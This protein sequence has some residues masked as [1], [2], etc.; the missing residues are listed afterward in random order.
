M[1]PSQST[2]VFNLHG[3]HYYEDKSN[4]QDQQCRNKPLKN[5]IIATQEASLI[6]F[7]SLKFMLCKRWTE[8]K[9]KKLNASFNKG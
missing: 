5:K 7:Y 3:S 2:L 9:N 6:F 4:E 8:N 1:K